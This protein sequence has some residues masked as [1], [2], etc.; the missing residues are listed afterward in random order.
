MVHL[1]YA[2]KE[3]FLSNQSFVAVFM[4]DDCSFCENLR[5]QVESLIEPNVSYDVSFFSV[6][7]T[8]E[9]I[10]QFS[11]TAFPV[12]SIFKN[13]IEY[14]S[15]VG[16]FSEDIDEGKKELDNFINSIKRILGG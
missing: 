6:D 9:F 15:K 1:N 7:V 8:E 5:D 12:V 16:L 3:E 10:N 4:K 13:G 2:S 11:L 14:T